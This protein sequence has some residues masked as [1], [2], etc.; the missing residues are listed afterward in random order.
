MT[1]RVSE[2]PS[3]KAVATMSPTP[4]LLNTILLVRKQ[5]QQPVETLC[6]LVEPP[7]CQVEQQLVSFTCSRSLRYCR[8]LLASIPV[9]GYQF[10]LVQRRARTAI[11]LKLLPVT[12][13]CS[14]NG[15]VPQTEL[16]LMGS[17]VDLT[18]VEDDGPAFSHALTL[19][20]VKAGF[21]PARWCH[22]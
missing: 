4:H 21:S 13:H 6:A 15:I 18:N 16:R 5:F 10:C 14:T 2:P 1:M 9:W 12:N 20:I 8:A 19:S 3:A 22:F 17:A 11:F 7:S